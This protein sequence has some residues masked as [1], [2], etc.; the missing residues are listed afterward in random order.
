VAQDLSIKLNRKNKMSR[1]LKHRFA[2]A[3]MR[4]AEKVSAYSNHLDDVNGPS[5]FRDK[6]DQRRRRFIKLS[7][8][9]GFAG[10]ASGAFDIGQELGADLAKTLPLERILNRDV[11]TLEPKVS[12]TIAEDFHS[13]AELKGSMVSMLSGG[14]AYAFMNAKFTTDALNDKQYQYCMVPLMNSVGTLSPLA[15]AS[16]RPALNRFDLA[17]T[18]AETYELNAYQA[19]MAGEAVQKYVLDNY[20]F[21]YSVMPTAAMTAL[22]RPINSMLDVGDAPQK[23]PRG[24]WG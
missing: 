7:L 24:P 22:A 17:D 19:R 2:K 4:T 20:G 12:R 13:Y 14:V 21:K 11:P 15:D 5:I 8:A 18:L 6:P 9:S 10:L 1:T 16:I 3:L 23:E